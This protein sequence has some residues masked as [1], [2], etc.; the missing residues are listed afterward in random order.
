MDT[1]L[2]QAEVPPAPVPAP[3]PFVHI[4]PPA[5]PLAGVDI[6]VKVNNDGHHKVVSSALPVLREVM[7]SP[8]WCTTVPREQVKV[9]LSQVDL[10]GDRFWGANLHYTRRRTVEDLILKFYYDDVKRIS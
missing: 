4:A 2:R 9:C 3:S 5:V 6:P 10:M 8:Q 1:E 7:R